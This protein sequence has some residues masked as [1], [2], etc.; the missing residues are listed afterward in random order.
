MDLNFYLIKYYI[1]SIY[2]IIMNNRFGLFMEQGN[3]LNVDRMAFNSNTRQDKTWKTN[4]QYQKQYPQFI[5]ETDV[6]VD[7]MFF[8]GTNEKTKNENPYASS[9][10]IIDRNMSNYVN[11]NSIKN[12]QAYHNS[13]RRIYAASTRN[14]RE[15]FHMEDLSFVNRAVNNDAL[16][17]KQNPQ[18]S[19]AVAYIDRNSFNM[20][21]IKLNK[22]KQKSEIDNNPFRMNPRTIQQPVQQQPQRP[23]QQ[24][25]NM[26]FSQQQMMPQQSLYQY[27]QY[28][29]HQQNVNNYYNNYPTGPRQ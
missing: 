1:I 2:Y 10:Q 6:N 16:K 23:V 4:P 9:F 26:F 19:N 17:P 8:N 29:Q 7:R 15:E 3:D 14:E 27:Q 24:Q 11:A 13:G 5:D 22:D 28:Q 12:K 25:N 20:P 21:E 18:T